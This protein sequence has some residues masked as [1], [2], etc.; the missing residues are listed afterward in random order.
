M[1][2][3]ACE[4][5]RVEHTDVLVLGGLGFIGSFISATLV[6]NGYSV[7]IFDRPQAGTDR[8][9]EYGVLPHTEVVRGDIA[10][11]DTVLKAME[12]VRTVIN[13][14]HTT[15]PS[16]SMQNP[17][18]DVTSN[19]ATNVS[20]LARLNETDVR[21]IV[22]F[23]SGGTVYGNPEYEP[24]REDHP[25][26]PTSSYGITKLA[27]EKYV[28]MYGSLF[29]IDHVVV[30]PS[31]VFGIGQHVSDSQGVI[32]A[33]IKT[34]LRGGCF[35][36]WGDGQARRDYIYLADL[37]SAVQS[38][39]EYTGRQHVFNVSTG[40]GHSVLDII[41]YVRET[42]E[43]SF[44]VVHKD[45]GAFHV[46]SNVLDSSRLRKE[47]GWE[48]QVTLEEGITR[49]AQWFIDNDQAFR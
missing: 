18:F 44:D 3:E 4:G 11:T 39:L 38:I 36:I 5:R 10:E 22:Y 45:A 15:V 12:G 14:V 29:N 47:T 40:V 34:A 35:E 21:R 46:S 31:N 33:V 13:L 20:W 41:S 16:S 1:C 7:R 19:V 37:A 49:T 2:M 9:S 6:N 43:L 23:S 8:I 17:V 28:A 24:I 42:L 32:G 25:T 26:N 48:P 27:I 30:R